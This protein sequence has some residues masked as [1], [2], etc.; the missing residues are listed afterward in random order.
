M[1]DFQYH[2]FASHV[3]GEGLPIR[4]MNVF[5]SMQSNAS[6]SISQFHS[7][8]APKR[9]EQKLLIAFESV[10]CAE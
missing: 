4:A 8:R 1:H 7:T 6:T 5:C 3:D 9:D 10:L 2:S